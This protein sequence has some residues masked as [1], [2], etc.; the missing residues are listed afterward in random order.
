M[1]SA[2]IRH[3]I[4]AMMLALPGSETPVSDFGAMAVYFC[5]YAHIHIQTHTHTYTLRE[6]QRLTEK[7]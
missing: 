6:K 2:T 1:E 4:I 5:K 3:A 7:E